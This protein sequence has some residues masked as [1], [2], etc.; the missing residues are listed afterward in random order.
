LIDDIGND[1][2]NMTDDQVEAMVDLL[3]GS[4]DNL[5][6]IETVEDLGRVLL[7]RNKP[8]KE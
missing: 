6:E 2:E 4:Y 7:A 8:R 1:L 3:S 5:D